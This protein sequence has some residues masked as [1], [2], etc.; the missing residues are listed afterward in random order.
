MS[1]MEGYWQNSF[2]SFFLFNLILLLVG[3]IYFEQLQDEY[4][5]YPI[6]YKV[7]VYVLLCSAYIAFLAILV[8]HV[9]IRFPKLKLKIIKIYNNIIHQRKQ[10][11][12]LSASINDVPSELTETS[13]TLENPKVVKFSELREPLLATFGTMDLDT[14]EV[15]TS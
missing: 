15:V 5:Q 14:H 1:P 13:P 2:D 3:N 9:F 4:K 6:E 10:A 12:T 11:L 8:V 7:F